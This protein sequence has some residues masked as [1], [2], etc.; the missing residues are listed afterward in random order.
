MTSAYELQDLEYRYNGTTILNIDRFSINA[1]QALALVG[2]NGSGKSTMLNLLAFISIP[3]KGQIR[4]FSV[5]EDNKTRHDF[6]RRIGY[7]QQNPYLFNSSVIENVEIGLKLRGVNKKMR[8]NRAVNILEQLKLIKLVNKRAHELSGGEIQK[9]ALARSLVLEPEV[10]IMDE[11]F[12]YLDKS[13]ISE[14]EDMLIS[15]RDTRLQTIIFSG[16]DYMRAQ[17][18]ADQV[19][20][21]I[22][23]KLV[24][25]SSVNLFR[26]VFSMEKRSFDTGRINIKVSEDSD[27]G[28][29]IAI[30]PTQIVL[31]RS[32]LDSSMRN[33]FKGQIKAMHARGDHIHLTVDAGESFQAIITKEALDE[34]GMSLGD[35]IWLSFKSS[36]VK[37][38]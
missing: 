15:I 19:C 35:T 24:R 22:N 37:I 26:G 18:L 7:V 13:F 17:I 27:S 28:E 23:G 29:L 14:F 3:D 2:P 9:V 34:L 33:R 38:L 36:A 11:P 10:L 16:H 32:E 6:R 5:I 4:F 1:G 12:T 30:E 8:H 31:S 20:S 21:I 25:E